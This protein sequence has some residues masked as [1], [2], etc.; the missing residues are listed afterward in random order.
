MNRNVTATDIIERT[1]AHMK[2]LGIHPKQGKY[3]HLVLQE[4][5]KEQLSEWEVRKLANHLGIRWFPPPYFAGT[6]LPSLCKIYLSVKY[7]NPKEPQEFIVLFSANTC[8]F[9]GK[10]V[11]HHT[12]NGYL[13]KSWF[14]E[15]VPDLD[16]MANNFQMAAGRIVDRGGSFSK[17]TSQQL[18]REFSAHINDPIN[19][20][21]S[22]GM[23][24]D[25]IRA[26][27]AFFFKYLPDVDGLC[28]RCFKL[29]LPRTGAGVRWFAPSNNFCEVRLSEPKI[30]EHEGQRRLYLTHNYTY[31]EQVLHVKWKGI[32]NDTPTLTTTLKQQETH[33]PWE[34]YDYEHLVASLPEH[35]G[36]K[37]LVCQC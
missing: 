18:R 11:I 1:D 31:N 21:Y 17:Q 8:K 26:T 19:S 27:N 15:F 34:L 33:I 13:D 5:E 2:R 24:M 9:G 35:Q 25:Q 7:T 29:S 37:F 23:S 4:A 36:H 30:F 16:Q 12:P 3:C 32:F 22:G 6:W 14:T 10:I 20:R 28:T